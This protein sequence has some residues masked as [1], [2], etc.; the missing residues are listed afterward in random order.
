MGD[1]GSPNVKK[2]NA[3]E[4]AVAQLFP[5][6]PNFFVQALKFA[7]CFVGL[8]ASYQT[9]GYMQELI[10]TT[11]FTPTPHVPGGGGGNFRRRPLCLFKSILGCNCCGLFLCPNQ[12]WFRFKQQR[13]TAL[14][15]YTMRAQQHNE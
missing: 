8:Q 5:S 7:L 6:N 13:G 11:Q 3:L 4:R 10:M 15:F 2:L 9:W 14:G 12:A 1:T